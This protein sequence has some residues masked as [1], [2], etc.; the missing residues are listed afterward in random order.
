MDSDNKVPSVQIMKGPSELLKDAWHIFANNWK[1]LVPMVGLPYIVQI[2]GQLFSMADNVFFAILS[3]IS[4]VVAIIFTT[5]IVPISII[6]SMRKISRGEIGTLGVIT[7]YKI[8]FK[9]FWSYV[10]V[11]IISILAIGG[12]LVLLA[13]PAIVLGIYVLFSQYSLV[14]D[15]HKGI[16]SFVESFA[17]VRGRWLAVLWSAFILVAVTFIL[18][19]LIGAVFGIVLKLAFGIPM[20]VLNGTVATS[21]KGL[22][23]LLLMI[24][25]A[26]VSVI[27]TPFATAYMF[28]LYETLK[29]NRPLQVNTNGFKKWL[30]G[31]MVVGIV[32]IAFLMM[33]LPL[34]IVKSF[35][36]LRYNSGPGESQMGDVLPANSIPANSL[37]SSGY[38]MTAEDKIK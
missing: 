25:L 11:M 4:A 15:G 13:I 1:L 17:I 28:K 34:L 29:A 3:M 20:N 6:D 24:R 5:V 23:A 22:E 14:V 19:F 18:T 36:S 12:S 16:N 7:Q 35:D 10:L 30:I 26:I 8:G 31:L 27:T 33:T 21:D 2:I 37:D 32:A 9:Y 38:N